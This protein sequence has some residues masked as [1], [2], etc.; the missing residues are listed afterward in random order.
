MW[1]AES[2]DDVTLLVSA[3][4]LP[5]RPPTPILVLL[6]HGWCLIVTV[7]G[8]STFPPTEPE[9][10]YLK[11]NNIEEPTGDDKLL[12]AIASAEGLF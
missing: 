2:L 11:N 1:R 3:A 8:H 12:P 4:H 9:P 10:K 7:P 5:V 6:G